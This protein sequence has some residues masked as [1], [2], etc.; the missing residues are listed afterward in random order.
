MVPEQGLDKDIN[1]PTDVYNLRINY[2]R[3]HHGSNLIAVAITLSVIYHHV[4][5]NQS[6]HASLIGNGSPW[7]HLCEKR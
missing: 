5:G 2:L 6:R 4:Q 7:T 1:I 3:A